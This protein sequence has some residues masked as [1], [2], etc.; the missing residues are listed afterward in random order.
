M[1]RR[2]GAERPLPSPAIIACQ[3]KKVG[4]P[5]ATL[6]RASARARIGFWTEARSVCPWITPSARV[7]TALDTPLRL[8]SAAMGPRKGWADTS[9]SV[10]ASACA[11]ER[12]SRPSLAKN[13]PPSGRRTLRKSL[14][15]DASLAAR[16][17]APA[18]ASSGVAASNTTTV[19][20]P[21]CGK[22]ASMAISCRRQSTLSEISL[23]V[24]LVMLKW[25]AMNHTAATE[26][27][28][29]TKTVTQAWSQASLTAAATGAA[30]RRRMTGPG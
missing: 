21:F 29:E 4:R 26:R 11:V 3:E 14:V 2:L 7:P 22:A 30:L 1:K 17:A 16:D 23:A 19:V 6:C 28:S 5:A 24:S 27:R 13:G 8:G 18:S 10:V 20:S 25:P 15:C 9:W 12:N